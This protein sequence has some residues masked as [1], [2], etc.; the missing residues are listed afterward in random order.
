MLSKKSFFN[1]GVWRKQVS[2]FWP[3]WGGYLTLWLLIVPTGL[4][5]WSAAESDRVTGL[6]LARYQ[7]DR[8]LLQTLPMA[9]L[10]IAFFSI[11]IAMAVYSYLYNNRSVSFF[12]ALPVSRENLFSTNF[13]TGL[14]FLIVPNAVL[15]LCFWGV[16][17]LA[18][19]SSGGCVL[20]T[21][22]AVTSLFAVFFFGLATLCAMLTAHTVMLP[23]LYGILNFLVVLA[24]ALGRSIGSNFL[25]GF[26][27]GNLSLTRWSPLSYILPSLN[28]V[29]G[30]EMAYVNGSY[31]LVSYPSFQD[32][33]YC[34]ALAAAG[35]LFALLGLLLY[36]RYASESAG[37]VISLSPLK[38]VFAFLSAAGCS[39]VL[40]TLFYTILFSDSPLNWLFGV[41]SS[42]VYQSPIM[43][44]IFAGCMLAG[45]LVG[46]FAA[47]M[48]LKKSFR[49]FTRRICLGAGCFV[50]ALAA[51]VVCLQTDV[52]Q[53]ESY[54]PEEA[55]I[56]S[57]R[58][59]GEL[60]SPDSY[61]A[62]LTLHN[63]ILAQK[64][65][66]L[67][68]L[69]L[70]GTEDLPYVSDDKPVNT[71]VS[72]SLTYHLSGGSTVSRQ[73]VLPAS[74]ALAEDPSTVVGQYYALLNTY[75][76][77]LSRSGMRRLIGK[78]LSEVHVGLYTEEQENIDAPLGSALF[79]PLLDA[80][81][82][83]LKAGTLGASM[84]M[85]DMDEKYIGGADLTLSTT[86]GETAYLHVTPRQEATWAVLL[87]V[88]EWG[89]QRK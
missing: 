58:L 60:V 29:T 55:K 35:I 70:L 53:I 48:L 27:S 2:R 36:R 46:Y 88:E 13:L 23:V 5:N 49:V 28:C 42:V 67:A 56:E 41:S 15:T 76:L 85:D 18:G 87:S 51:L 12:H 7:M 79:T 74:N 66:T 54:V 89:G 82:A 62:V 86:D 77:R 10:I 39:L 6:S 30:S 14:S 32:W 69:A 37:E 24:E 75:D 17:L 44:W 78:Q 26:T 59:D 16:E 61:G 38:P 81:N 20:L 52:F 3:L 80:L 84:P 63:A 25:Y 8:F 33:G 57:L 65:T 83:D 50:L 43:S 21:W 47:N 73:Y 71:T 4:L 34:L 9:G 72:I 64:D 68:Q 22:F 45:G 19:H 40:G 1:K 31:S 11:F